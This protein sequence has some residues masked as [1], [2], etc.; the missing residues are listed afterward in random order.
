MKKAA[1]VMLGLG[2]AMLAG[3][4]VIGYRAG[5]GFVHHPFVMF[6]GGVILVLGGLAGRFVLP[7]L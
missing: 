6:V 7:R 1:N 5:A 2:L 4:I 3:Y